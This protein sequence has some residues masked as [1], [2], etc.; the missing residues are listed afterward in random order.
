VQEKEILEKYKRVAM[1]GVS[2]NPDRDSNRVINYLLSHGYDV[3]P[4]NPNA[5]E[6]AGKKSY[7]DLKSI[8][9]KIEIVDIFR[10]SE[11]VGPVVDEAIKIGA[12]IIW[13]QE[14]IENKEAAEKARGAGLNVVMNKCMK[15]THQALFSDQS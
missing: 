12:D 15:K 1:V 10:K 5:G 11:E 7:P 2:P 8:P 14:G 13:M 3:T 6:I 4:V 9:G